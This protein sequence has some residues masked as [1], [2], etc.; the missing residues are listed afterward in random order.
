MTELSDCESFD[1]MFRPLWHN[2]GMWQTGTL[3]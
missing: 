1:D 3:P 2:I